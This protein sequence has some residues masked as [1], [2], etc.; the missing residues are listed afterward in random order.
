G[1]STGSSTRAKDGGQSPPSQNATADRAPSGPPS[2]RVVG[3]GRW[4]QPPS[5]TPTGRASPG[6]P[7]CAPGAMACSLYGRPHRPGSHPAAGWV[8]GCGMVIKGLLVA[9]AKGL[10]ACVLGGWLLWQTAEHAGPQTSE[11]VVHV[12]ESPVVVTIDGRSYPVST[13]R[14]SPVV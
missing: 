11:V 10:G 3:S 1:T 7:V 2:T 12:T 5:T 14:D 6:R 13:W 4:G 8:G 9:V